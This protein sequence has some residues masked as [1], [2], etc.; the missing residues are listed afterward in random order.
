M[1][2]SAAS[3]LCLTLGVVSAI[4]HEILPR[5]QVSRPCYQDNPL[6][7]LEG[8]SSEASVFC[9]KYLATTGVAL[10]SQFTQWQGARLTSAC[11]CFEKTA[12]P[13]VPTTT[14]STKGP[15]KA[16][17]PTTTSTTAVP[18]VTPPAVTKSTS[19]SS[20]TAATTS[21]S[22]SAALVDKSTTGG[23]AKRGLVYDYSSKN[24]YAN[25]FSGSQYVGFGSNWG[26]TRTTGNGITL[27]NTWN[28]VPTLQVNSQLQSSDW[29]KNVNAAIKSGTK[30]LFA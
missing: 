7:A 26:E 16:T 28:F 3:A 8:L 24:S 12:G 18:P 25:L 15:S 2:F 11:S 22:T 14:S 9:P 6:R 20:S 1:H 10:P 13:T 30:W 27:P 5:D 21:A 19:S 4:P 29:S 23:S 17:S